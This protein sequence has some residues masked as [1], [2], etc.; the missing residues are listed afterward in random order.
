MNERLSNGTFSDP[1]AAAHHPGTPLD[2]ERPRRRQPRPLLGTLCGFYVGLAAITLWMATF[3]GHGGSFVSAY[4]FPLSR[5]AFAWLYPAQSVP[6]LMWYVGA[7]LQW[8]LIGALVDVAR[9]GIRR[10]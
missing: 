10:R 5:A 7:L 4:L 2:Y 1:R 9:V 8:V 6:V 3:S